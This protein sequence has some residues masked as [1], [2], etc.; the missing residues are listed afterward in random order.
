[1]AYRVT[2]LFAGTEQ[3][4]TY[5]DPTEATPEQ[6]DIQVRDALLD[7]NGVFIYGDRTGCDYIPTRYIAR[8]TTQPVHP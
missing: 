3:T 6:Y 5:H 8:L 7:P 2:I 1:M 4:A